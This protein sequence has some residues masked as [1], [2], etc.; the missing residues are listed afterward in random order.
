MNAWIAHCKGRY[1][2]E[3]ATPE[4]LRSPI[5]NDDQLTMYV[6]T[7][8]PGHNTYTSVYGFEK[9]NRIDNKKLDY[10]RA[11]IDTIFID[12]DWKEMP[13]IAL[14]EARLFELDCYHKGITP[15]IYFT[16]MKGFALYLDF[17][18]VEIEQE[19]KKP[20]IRTF[21]E[22]IRD[23]LSL[24]T[25]D[26]Q[27]VDGI[28]R[29]SRLPNTLHKKSGLYCIPLS[30][31]E[32]WHM[33]GIQHILDLAKNVSETPIMVVN[34]KV[35]PEMLL[36]IQDI[37]KETKV[38]VTEGRSTVPFIL[39]QKQPDETPVRGTPCLGVME[40]MCG[41]QEGTRD[42]SMCGLIAG[43][44]IQM[45][46]SPAEINSALEKWMNTC[47]PPLNY[48]ESERHYKLTEIMNKQYRPC[49]FL[50]RAGVPACNTCPIK[51]QK[52]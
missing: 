28:S 46:L 18:P 36:K 30:R 49:T 47:N 3:F 35:I 27:C 22:Y 17:E 48:T 10:S 40:V 45:G 37:L 52:G 51:R 29:I 32:L 4:R 19:F 43:M 13:E 42:V 5:L 16:G 50:I 2:R 24:K 38:E 25:L 44:N 11:I 23:T 26:S 41:V 1:P 9:W 12:L 6:E 20:V 7:Y 21:I 34:N 8:M 14:Y 33:D 15:R 31:D 39:P